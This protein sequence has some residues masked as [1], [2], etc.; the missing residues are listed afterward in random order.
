MSQSAEISKKRNVPLTPFVP[1]F[2]LKNAHFQTILSSQG[3]RKRN[4]DKRFSRFQSKQRSLMLNGGSGVRLEGYYN[5]VKESIADRLVILIHGWEGSHES[6][7]MKSMAATMLQN[8]YDVFRLNM[9]DHGETHH[10]NREV[11]NSTM[12]E[13]VMCAIEDLQARFDYRSTS[14]IGF[15]LGGNFSL[16]VAANAHDKNIELEQV[17]A[18]CPVVHAAQSNVVLNEKRNSLYGKYFVKKW[19]TSLRKKLE[20]WPEFEFGDE[21]ERFKTLDE[22]NNALIPKYTGFTELSSYFDAYA[23]DGDKLAKTICPCY[24]HFARDDMIIPVEG[25]S[26]MAD[27]TD[28]HVT[29]TDHGGHCGFIMNWQGDSWQDV[30][31]LEIIQHSSS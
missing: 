26:M 10:L 5:R 30:R 22:M 24:L 14:L 29:I 2:G 11:F 23:I 17:I 7:Y 9:R 4:R 21:L 13:E 20:H 27:N 3:P 6:T 28:L 18:F 31:A 25:A 12:I 16:R 19:R 1:P 15:S 8:G